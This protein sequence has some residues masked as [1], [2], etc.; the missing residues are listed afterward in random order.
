MMWNPRGGGIPVYK[1]V[2]GLSAENKATLQFT[3]FDTLGTIDTLPF[4]PQK[5]GKRD[6]KFLSKKEIKDAWNNTLDTRVS[7]ESADDGAGYMFKQPSYV[8]PYDVGEPKRDM[9]E[10]GVARTSLVRRL[11]GMNSVKLNEGF[12]K[13]AQAGAWL[14]ARENAGSDHYITDKVDRSGMSKEFEN[15]CRAGTERA[16]LFARPGSQRVLDSFMG[17]NGNPNLGHRFYVLSRITSEVGFGVAPRKAPNNKSH[18][19]MRFNWVKQNNGIET[20]T[21]RGENWD[22]TAWPTPGY[23]PIN[24]TWF[25]VNGGKFWHFAVNDQYQFV[26]GTIITVK[27]YNSESDAGSGTNPQYTWTGTVTDYTADTKT[28]VGSEYKITSTDNAN[29]RI[30][31]PRT[32]IFTLPQE[33]GKHQYAADKVYTVEIKDILQRTKDEKGIYTNFTGSTTKKT[34]KYGVC[35]FDLDKVQ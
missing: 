34:F 4:S 14:L 31:D 20:L 11:A 19:S 26:K 8:D 35:F 10:V 13:E 1:E 12:Y 9:L 24:T 16:N 30:I 3:N 15:L 32:C 28:G 23:F 27:Q 25:D 33:N 29:F 22:L 2:A 17:E 21:D 6:L 5:S 7:T 18:G